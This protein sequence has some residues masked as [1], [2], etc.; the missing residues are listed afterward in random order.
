MFLAAQPMTASTA[1]VDMIRSI[2][3][4]GVGRWIQHIICFFHADI[5][6]FVQ[7]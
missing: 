3:G 7:Y 4:R 2:K 1:Q 5:Y 6:L